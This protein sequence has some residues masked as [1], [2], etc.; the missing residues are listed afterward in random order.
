MTSGIFFFQARLPTEG[1][2]GTKEMFFK[3]KFSIVK[4]P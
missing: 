3:Q 4:G 1:G 2:I